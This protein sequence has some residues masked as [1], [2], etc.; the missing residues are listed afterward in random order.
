MY[1]GY[2]NTGIYIL[3]KNCCTESALWKGA[4]P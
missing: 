3:A 1:G 2:F 4:L